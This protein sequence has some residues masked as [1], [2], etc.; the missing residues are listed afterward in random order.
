M[1]DEQ[2]RIM[3]IYIIT[4]AFIL[5]MKVSVTS[6]RM[7]LRSLLATTLLVFTLLFLSRNYYQRPTRKPFSLKDSEH[8]L[9]AIGEST[10]LKSVHFSN[11]GASEFFIFLHNP[12]TDI[13]ESKDLIEGRP[14][15]DHICR[16]LQIFLQGK[17]GKVRMLDIGGNIGF[18]SLLAASMYQELEIIAVEPAKKHFTLFDESLKANPASLSRRIHLKKVALGATFGGYAC[19]V[20]EKTNAAATSVGVTSID[21]SCIDAA[22]I[23][24]IDRIVNE[25]WPYDRVNSIDIVKMDIEGYELFAMGGAKHLLKNL[26]PKLFITEFVPWRMKAFGVKDPVEEFLSVFYKNGYIVKD[27]IAKETLFTLSAAIVYFNDKGQDYF[28]DL[29]IIDN[30]KNY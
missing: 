4:S 9:E 16:L 13:Y 19:M 29:Q 21:K 18:M 14:W 22:P 11:F 30:K 20:M 6:N 3:T 5:V 28:T 26:R 24:T 10:I 8:V 17:K 2:M 23:T 1:I 27:A 12:N 7:S 25:T 15:H